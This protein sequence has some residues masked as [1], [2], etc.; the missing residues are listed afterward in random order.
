[1]VKS[2]SDQCVS[3]VG[4][5]PTWL[6]SFLPP[7]RPRA[8]RFLHNVVAHPLC[9]LMPPLGEFLHEYTARRMGSETS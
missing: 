3:Q 7:V 9:E 5:V 8:W 4:V 2:Q 6:L 1:M